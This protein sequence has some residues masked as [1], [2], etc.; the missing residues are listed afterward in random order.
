MG[1]CGLWY[2]PALSMT[3]NAASATT[4]LIPAAGRVPEGLLALSNIQN[5]ALIPVAGRPVIHWTMSYLR[6]LGLTKFVIAVARRGGFIEDFVDCAF[7]ST[8]DVSFI[9]P[10][11]AGGLGQTVADLAR[12]VKTKRAL[13]VLGDT[14]FQ[15]VDAALLASDSPSVLVS[16]VEE[17]YRWCV[18]ETDDTRT[19]RALRDKEPDVK[20]PLHALIGVYC[21]PD[22]QLLQRSAEAAVADADAAG[23]P[24]EMKAI[25]DGVAAV[26]PLRAER[27]G[28]W[29]D[30]G[31]ADR[32][33]ASHQAL[34]QKRAFNELKI[35][36]I[37]GTITKRSRN[38]EKFIDEINY[39]RLLPAELAVLF[40]RVVDYSVAWDAPYLTLE[41]YGYPSLSE[42]YVFENV[43]PG[44]WE[45]IFGHLR[46]IVAERF[47]AHVRPLPHGALEDMLL[48]KTRERLARLQ[49]PAE[50][51]RL[52][53][54][55]GT[56]RLNGREVKNLA[57]LWPKLEAEVA[58]MA[59][60]AKGSIVHGDLCFSNILY[61]L[62]SRVC[63]L[64]DP[65]G[66][67]GKQG[68][69]G[70][71]RYDVAKLYHSVHGQ[72][73]FLV[74]DLF[75]V[76]LDGLALDLELRTRPAHEKIRE[77]F[78]KVFFAAGG[79]FAK[80]DVAV[81]TALLFASMLP[82]HDD[83]PRRQLA[84]YATALKLLD[85]VFA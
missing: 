32:Q 29:L 60:G 77:R 64:V 58:R 42:A 24:T 17:S 19:V 27:A 66:S 10:S 59:A 71:A 49:G 68:T 41:Y 53:R 65:R 8:C 52:V 39:L 80:R 21:F 79:P 3:L 31:N 84:M 25:L 63:K 43:D 56:V 11:K 44:V 18:A 67:F 45:R 83:A 69:T 76:K 50:L 14:H 70:D 6:S 2:L 78:E 35:D 1:C 61:D 38:V 85:E 23:R 36:P 7:G 37:L 46:A 13:V 47:M 20:G 75:S 16:P 57:T 48:H 15:F 73:D 82:L 5:P 33:A 81:I 30:C 72:Y 34:L 9:T 51:T 28:D 62:R 55:D 40:P 26:T 4:V 12:S 22:A 54:H 74:N